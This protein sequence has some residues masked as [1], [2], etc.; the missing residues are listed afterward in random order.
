MRGESEVVDVLS[1]RGR[2]SMQSVGAD[3]PSILVVDDE[4]GIVAIA[5]LALEPKGYTVIGAFNGTDALELYAQHHLDLALAILD[6]MLPDMRGNELLERMTAIDDT[7]RVIAVSGCTDDEI[8]GE[9]LAGTAAFI[10]KPF[11]VETLTEQIIEVI[12]A[13][14]P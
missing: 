6:Y 2:G 4:P 14:A 10:R 7:V 13:P 8:A 1:S 12:L 9:F 5:Q 3:G 11:G